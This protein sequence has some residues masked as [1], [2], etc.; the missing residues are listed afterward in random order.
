MDAYADASFLLSL[1]LEDSNTREA[2]RLAAEI[3]DSF[4]YT[5]FHRLEVQNGV[6]LAVFRKEI[7]EPK[8]QLV[9]RQIEHDLADGIL[10]SV[11]VRWSEIFSR[12]ETLSADFTEVEGHRAGDILHVALAL[13]TKTKVFFTFDRRQK[14]LAK[15]AGFKV[16]P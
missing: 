15:A 4:P 1:L 14:A 12:A 6:R 11:N 7:K 13:E 3:K 9:L 8:R 2:N 5:D 10:V 16:K